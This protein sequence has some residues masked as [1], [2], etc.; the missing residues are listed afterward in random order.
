LQLVADIQSSARL[1]LA[2]RFVRQFV[3]FVYLW[4]CLYFLWFLV[5]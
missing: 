2:A 3:G 1:R 4:V 5:R